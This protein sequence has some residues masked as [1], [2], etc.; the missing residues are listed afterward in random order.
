MALDG[1]SLLNLCFSASNRMEGIPQ[2]GFTFINVTRSESSS[3][4]PC[5]VLE[6][7]GG[8]DEKWV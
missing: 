5:I 8:P 1:A 3:A 4:E 2:A 6:N 7:T